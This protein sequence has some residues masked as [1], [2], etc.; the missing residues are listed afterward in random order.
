[1]EIQSL[2]SALILKWILSWMETHQPK[3]VYLFHWTDTR[4]QQFFFLSLNERHWDIL[5]KLDV[6]FSRK[7][8]KYL[9]NKSI[10]FCR[11]IDMTCDENTVY[12]DQ[13]L[14]MQVHLMRIFSM[15]TR[16]IIVR[17][18]TLWSKY[19]LRINSKLHNIK[20]RSFL[21][22]TSKIRSKKAFQSIYRIVRD[23]G[24][25]ENRGVCRSIFFGGGWTFFWRKDGVSWK[26][27]WVKFSFFMG[28][29]QFHKS[30][31]RGSKF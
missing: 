8:E 6:I 4:Y 28:A 12:L 26:L 18:N 5:R 24:L 11:L 10:Y 21:I 23:S 29:L 1:M 7:S 31:Y 30:I 25:L 20:D 15:T 19:Y 27:S 3:C 14:I 16:S 17:N 13:F 2:H 9:L 22:D